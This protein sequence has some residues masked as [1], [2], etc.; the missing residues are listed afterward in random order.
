[1][2]LLALIALSACAGQSDDPRQR[3]LDELAGQV[4]QIREQ[5][6]ERDRSAALQTLGA[7]RSDVARFASDGTLSS[8]LSRNILSA[9][10]SVEVLLKARQTSRTPAAPATAA[11]SAAPSESAVPEPAPPEETAPPTAPV[12]TQPADNSDQGRGNDETQGN[13]QGPG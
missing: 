9:A 10:D 11:P 8:D 1:M 13:G 7:L 6:A 5:A 2:A 4:Q 12:Q 3:A